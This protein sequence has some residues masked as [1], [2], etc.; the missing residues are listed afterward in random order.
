MKEDRRFPTKKILIFLFLALSYALTREFTPDNF[1]T[2]FLLFKMVFWL[3]VASLISR[4]FLSEFQGRSKKKL[5]IFLFWVLIVIA[6]PYDEILRWE[7]P[8]PASI[9]L[10][11]G[12]LPLTFLLKTPSSWLLKLTFILLLL[13]GVFSNNHRPMSETFGQLTYLWL[14][15]SFIIIL[16]SH[17]SAPDY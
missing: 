16:L 9:M 5:F 17:H 8:I 15:M 6:L 4:G 11:V 2:S 13:A 1:P 14:V 12:Y 7:N 10:F 3:G